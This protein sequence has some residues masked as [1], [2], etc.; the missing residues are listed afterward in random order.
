MQLNVSSIEKK[1]VLE[2]GELR[3]IPVVKLIGKLDHR[4]TDVAQ[5]V[6]F[7]RDIKKN[8]EEP[9]EGLKKLEGV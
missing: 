3:E 1:M 5:T 4:I 6:R 7:L 9:E 8:L 2:N